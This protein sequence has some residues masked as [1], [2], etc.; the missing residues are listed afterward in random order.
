LA[1]A[2]VGEEGVRVQLS[3]ERTSESGKQVLFALES[4]VNCRN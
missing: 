2:L 4:M 3:L 1:F